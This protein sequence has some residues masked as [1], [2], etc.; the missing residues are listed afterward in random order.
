MQT[1]RGIAVDA[2]VAI[3]GDC[4]LVWSVVGDQA[5]FEFGHRTGSIGVVATK[6][7]LT[8]LVAGSTAAPLCLLPDV[9]RRPDRRRP[10]RD[11][12][13]GWPAMVTF[14]SRRS[15]TFRAVL[16]PDMLVTVTSVSA[17]V[18]TGSVV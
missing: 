13:A 11:Q 6:D 5:E 9:G 18:P 14:A 3:D 12:A 10:R 8:K 4:D 7:A 16:V 2:W 1:N 15:V 17:T